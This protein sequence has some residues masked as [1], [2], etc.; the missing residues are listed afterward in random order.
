MSSGIAGKSIFE[1]Y[2]KKNAANIERS[3]AEKPAEVILNFFA[4]WQRENTRIRGANRRI[5][6]K[7]KFNPTSKRDL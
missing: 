3:Q 7:K 4:V 5:F 6:S 1:N 2:C